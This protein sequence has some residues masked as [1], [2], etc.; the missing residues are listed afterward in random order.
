MR[1]LGSVLPKGDPKATNMIRLSKVGTFID[2]QYDIT[3]N[4]T[5]SQ[6]RIWIQQTCA[7]ATRACMNAQRTPTRTRLYI[8]TRSDSNARQM[9]RAQV[10]MGAH[11]ARN[12]KTES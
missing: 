12:F 7:R 3:P 10:I 9:A 6:S 5:I 4:G 11:A 1:N 8:H 2:T